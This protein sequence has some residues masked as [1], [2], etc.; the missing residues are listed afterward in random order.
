MLNDSYDFYF[1]LPSD[2]KSQ[3]GDT[4]KNLNTAIEEWDKITNNDEGEQDFSKEAL[5]AR[6]KDLLVKLKEQ[7]EDL[8]E[9]EPSPSLISGEQP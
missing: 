9:D 7:I 6:T 8:S 1:M 5:E 3:L 4:L 2:N